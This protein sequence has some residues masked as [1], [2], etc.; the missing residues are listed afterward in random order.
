MDDNQQDE[1]QVL[2]T[3]STEEVTETTE[4]TSEPQQEES[5]EE[6]RSR[7]EEERKAREETEK[8]NKQLYERLKK[9]DAPKAEASDGLSNKDV[10]FLAKADIHEDDLD[11]VLDWAKF[12]KVSVSEAYKQLKPTLEVRAEQRDTA[13]A[14]NKSNVRRGPTTVSDDVLLAKASKGQL[15][16]SE[17]EIERLIKAKAKQK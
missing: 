1:T 12:K 17:E 5:V 13:Q 3:E 7:L 10:L 4:D 6:L 8:K 14:S 15:P 2:E 9:Q 11:E 16:E